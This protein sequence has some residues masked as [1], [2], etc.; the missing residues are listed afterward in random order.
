MRPRDA[1]IL[2]S[3]ACIEVRLLIQNKSRFMHILYLFWFLIL[4]IFICLY[5]LLPIVFM[6]WS[7][8][9]FTMYSFSLWPSQVVLN[10]LFKGI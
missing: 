2:V 5:T 3:S 7:S 10:L 8:S 4:G 6:L 9:I 1:K